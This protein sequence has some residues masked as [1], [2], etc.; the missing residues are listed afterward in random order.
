MSLNLKQID[1]YISALI[2]NAD[3][4]VSEAN[5]LFDAGGFARA[6]ILAHLAR[7]E[8][9]KCIILYAAG[10]RV[11]CGID[12]DWKSTMKRLR[13]HKSKI[14]QETLMNAVVLSGAGN[15]EMSRSL[16]TNT[17]HIEKQKMTKRIILFMLV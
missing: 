12:V 1:D 14:R 17:Q 6:H 9:S 3:K 10:R 7:E 16:I 2:E 8:L 11:Q 5:T 15:Q 13:D 4:L